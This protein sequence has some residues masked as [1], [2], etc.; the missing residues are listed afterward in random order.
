MDLVNEGDSHTASVALN[1]Y[2]WPKKENP[3][4]YV[5]YGVTGVFPSSG[6]Y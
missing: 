4:T 6:P 2:S 5:P 3:L 1:S